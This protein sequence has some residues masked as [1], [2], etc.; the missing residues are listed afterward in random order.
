MPKVSIVISIYNVEAYLHAAVES[1]IQQTERDIQII[2]VDDGSTDNSGRLCD[3]YAKQDARIQVVRKENG[4]LSSARN[5]GIAVATA[6]YVLLLDGD[7]YLHFQAVERVLETVNKYPTDI[8]QFLY[9]EVPEYKEFEPLG[10]LLN[11]TRATTAKEAFDN[12]YQRG[13]VY[14]SSCTKLFKRELLKEIPFENVRH[15]DEAWCTIAFARGINITYITDVLYGYV[16]RA[17]SI[18]HSKFQSSRLQILR[19]KEARLKVLQELSLVALEM[20]E[21]NKLFATVYT[22]Y[23]DAKIAKD[24]ASCKILMGYLK[25]SGVLKK[26]KVS[27]RMKS[28]YYLAKLSARASLN[29]YTM[30]WKIR[31]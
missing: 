17:G 23:K 29:I 27:G 13:G 21:W 2:L 1:A 28:F 7:D 5:A 12:L 19:V 26:A 15:E 4:G 24:K 9:E 10:E 6:E 22:L 14:A 20:Q 18:I 8:V 11:I 31:R 30:Y 25:R 3:E 16:M